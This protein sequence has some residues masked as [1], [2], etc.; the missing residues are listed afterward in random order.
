MYPVGSPASYRR[1]VATAAQTLGMQVNEIPVSDVDGMKAAIQAF[2]AEPNGGLVPTPGIVA[3]GARE[4]IQLAAEY[5]LPAIY[6]SYLAPDGGL[7]CYYNDVP[8]LRGA[9]RYVDCLLH[10]AKVS[11]LPGQYPTNFHLAINLK[12]ARTRP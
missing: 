10:G 8:D 1:S 3:L 2:A 4:V 9:A 12:T 11:D 7:L 5:R 6:G